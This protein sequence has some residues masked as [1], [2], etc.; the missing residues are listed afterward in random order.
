MVGGIH[1]VLATK[2]P[3]MQAAYDQGYVLIGPELARSEQAQP[4]FREEIWH[5]ELH[6][7]LAGLD[8]GCRMGRWLVPGEPRCLLLNS[9]SLLPRKDEILA[10][11]WEW[12]ELDSITGGWDYLEPLLFAHAAALVIETLARGYHLPRRQTVVAQAHEWLAGGTMLYLRQ[13]MPEVGTVFT[14]HAT[15]LGR[16]LSARHPGQTFYQAIE[17]IDPAVAAHDLGVR[18]KHSM[19]LNAAQACDVFTTVSAITAL[20]CR[21]FLGR[22]PDRIL[23]NGLADDFPPAALRDP[24]AVHAARDRLFH[25]AEL[26]TGGAYDRAHTEILVTSGRYE[27]GNKGVDVWL[28]ALATLNQAPEA[29]I[30]ADAPAPEAARTPEAAPT[31]EAAQTPEPPRRLLGFVLMP[32]G[33]G[34]PRRAILEA[35]REG[36]PTGVVYHSTHDLRDEA[37]DPVL[38]RLAELGLGNGPADRVHVIFIPIYL[39]GNDSLIRESYYALL[40]GADLSVFASFYEPWGY[41]PMESIAFGIPT[42]TSDLAGFGRWAAPRGDW[43]QTGVAVLAREGRSV[44]QAAAA[45]ADRIR[46]YLALS[47]EDCGALG[48]AARAT[49]LACRWASFATVYLEAHAEA[50]GQA[51]LRAQTMPRARFAVTGAGR[52]LPAAVDRAQHAHLRPFV[53]RNLLPPALEGL[54]ALAMN[55]WWTTCPQA[56][57]LFADLDPERWAQSGGNPVVLLEMAGADR[58]AAA[59]ADEAYLAR[60][61]AVEARF[62]QATAAPLSPDAAPA[63][64]SIAYFCME[65][66]LADSLKIYAGGLGVLAGDHLKTASDLGLPLVAVGLAYRD[67]YFRQRLR[68]D[69]LQEAE[70]DLPVAHGTPLEPVLQANGRPLVVE[71]A[72]PGGPVFARAWR[73]AVGALSLYLLDTDLE[74]NSA[75]QRRIT[76]QLYGGDQGHRVQQELILGVGGYRLLRALGLDPAVYHMNEGHSA[77]L[78]LA[79]L[80]DLV[81]EAGL[82]ADEAMELIRHT[83]VFTTHTPVAAGHDAFPE[84][85]VR[86]YLAPFEIALQQDAVAALHPYL[87]RDLPGGAEPGVVLP[88]GRAPWAPDPSF[89]MTALALRGSLRVNAVSRIHGRVS[90]RLFHDVYPGL[91]AYEVPIADITNGV[92]VPTWL[93]GAWQAHFDARLPGDWRQH[94]ADADY[95]DAVRRLDPREVWELRQACKQRLLDWLLPFVR[96]SWVARREN[97]AQLGDALRFL[98]PDSLL[99]GFARRFAPYKRAT[100]LFH[101]LDRLREL[102]GGTVPIVFLFAGKAHPSDGMGKDLIAQLIAHSRREGLLGH[103]LFLEDYGMGM[104]RRLVAGCDLW[105]NTPTRP[106]EASGTSG[107]KAAINGCLNLSVN[108]GWWAEGYNGRNG[109]LIDELPSGEDPAYQDE[110]DSA[111]L[112][113]LLENEVLP[114]FAGRVTGGVSFEWVEMVKE[115][116]ASILPAFSSARM[117]EDY[118]ERLY[119]PAAAQAEALKADAYRPLFRLTQFKQRLRRHW[120]TLDFEDLSIEGL[121]GE[122]GPRAGQ[123]IEAQVTLRH[124]HLRAD[125]LQAQIVLTGPDENAPIFERHDMTLVAATLNGAEAVSTWRG[126]VH[127]RRTGPQALGLRVTPAR[128]DPETGLE[129]FML[130]AK[131]L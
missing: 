109:W 28:D 108:D 94:L 107:M 77:F 3:N 2:V 24:S 101:D 14:T 67:G 120:E 66:G 83:T 95:W 88:L 4:V 43:R 126:A 113:A 25:L 8:F 111:T 98:G 123:A 58:L 129:T 90:R 21:H 11:Y 31:P 84:A 27:Y 128:A 10:R 29:E 114:R 47:D 85:L 32:A 100:L 46:D 115:S 91:H 106:L 68:G 34:G 36:K 74:A 41:T 65:Y 12:Y 23:V 26:C 130:L 110:I 51:A 56:E 45:L 125:E 99:V 6:A 40:A 20:E 70:A 30:R 13:R 96:R 92:H 39:D 60:L 18:A 93:A 121:D 79:R 57:A 61:A 69:G 80:A 59:A 97:P 38:R 35:E 112:Y 86:P 118:S 82:K 62:R 124:P 9:A 81:R 63:R 71:V 37:G 64:A 53:V 49:S 87:A 22:E 104:A 33:H 50:A 117:L 7:C 122:D 105:L 73:V 54:R 55:L 102:V 131:W 1:T 127:C 15:T 75:E 5:A 78:I 76:D 119:R 72:F 17:A 89:S 19:E 116:I 44:Q 103:V 48:E 42:V 16:A 52:A